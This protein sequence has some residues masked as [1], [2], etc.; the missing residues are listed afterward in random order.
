VHPRDVNERQVMGCSETGNKCRVFLGSG[1]TN[2]VMD[3]GDGKHDAQRVAFLEQAAEQGQGG[4][5]HRDCDGN[6]LAGTKEAV[7]QSWRLHRCGYVKAI[8]EPLS[9]NHT[10][11]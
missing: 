2:T 9:S 7:S 3:V 10:I 5:D 6:P 1:S 8:V 11:T 4:G